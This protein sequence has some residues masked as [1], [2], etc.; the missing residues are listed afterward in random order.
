LKKLAKTTPLTKSPTPTKPT[1]NKPSTP[2]SPTLKKP[3]PANLKSNVKYV[4]ISNPKEAL[5]LKSPAF[6][7]FNQIQIEK[8]ELENFS[9]PTPRQSDIVQKEINEI[10]NLEINTLSLR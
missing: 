4:S 5:T 3:S 8:I 10:S 9:T 2:S 6:I 7:K 1:Y